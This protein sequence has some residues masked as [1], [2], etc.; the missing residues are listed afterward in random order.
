[1]LQKF[2]NNYENLL[3]EKQ[4]LNIWVEMSRDGFYCYTKPTP[5]KSSMYNFAILVKTTFLTDVPITLTQLFD[6]AKQTGN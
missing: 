2:S 1:M 6:K 5:H 4:P 3:K